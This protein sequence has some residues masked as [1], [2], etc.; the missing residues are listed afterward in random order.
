MGGNPRQLTTEGFEILETYQVWS[1]N[2]KELLY[3]STRTGTKDL[4][5]VP[6]DGGKARQL[7]RNVRNDFG[8]AWSPDG[9][10][11]AFISDR[12]KQ[13]DVWV[14]PSA[15]GEERRVTSNAAQRTA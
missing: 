11:V 13:T 15:G 10:Y 5:V 6:I 3:T 7:T 8:G 4:W 2:G 9:H 14:V 1:P 12:G